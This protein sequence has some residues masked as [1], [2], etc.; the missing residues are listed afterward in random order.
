MS[1]LVAFLRQPGIG[2]DKT[3]V[4]EFL[5]DHKELNLQV[6]RALVR[7]DAR[8]RSFPRMRTLTPAMRIPIPT[9]HA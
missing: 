6:S 8:P 7:G 2:L 1:G 9:A 3:M 5:G 4:G